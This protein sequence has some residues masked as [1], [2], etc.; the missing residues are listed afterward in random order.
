MAA[1]IIDRFR[2]NVH[3]IVN[4]I[5]G[6]TTGIGMRILSH[7][8][9]RLFPRKEAWLSEEDPA[10]VNRQIV[11]KRSDPCFIFEMGAILQKIPFVL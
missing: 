8:F 5:P 3:S 9:P 1:K 6:F 7:Y 10:L 4:G 11:Y 2:N